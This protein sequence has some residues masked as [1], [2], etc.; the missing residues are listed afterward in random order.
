MM[1]ALAIWEGFLKEVTTVCCGNGKD[2]REEGVPDSRTACSKAWRFRGPCSFCVG[3]QEN[4]TGF[5]SIF[6]CEKTK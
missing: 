3:G 4:L 2:L 6:P 5:P 1:P